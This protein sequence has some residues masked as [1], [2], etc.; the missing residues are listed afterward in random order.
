M[1]G[2]TNAPWHIKLGNYW[3]KLVI[4]PQ[5]MQLSWRREPVP[6][7]P[8]RFTSQAATQASFPPDVR[9]PYTFGEHSGGMGL[10]RID[11]AEQAVA[12]NYAGPRSGNVD[13]GLDA[14]LGNRV[15][16]SAYVNRTTLGTTITTGNQD[17][18]F[19][20]SSYNQTSYLLAGR[21]VFRRTATTSWSLLQDLGVGISGTDIIEFRGTQ[22]TPYLYVACGTANDIQV[23]DIAGASWHTVNNTKAERWAKI[24]DKL[25]R[26]LSGEVDAAT[27]GGT[28]PTFAGPII[29]G[30]KVGTC[31]GL[32]NHSNRITIGKSSGLFLLTAD[33]G[34]L[35]QNLFPEFWT[36]P[37]TDTYTFSKGVSF[38]NQLLTIYKK[39]LAAFTQDFAYINVGLDK[40]I[41]NN[42]PVTGQVTAIASDGNHIYYALDSG[43]IIKGVVTM[44]SGVITGVTHHPWLY[45]GTTR[46]DALHVDLTD[47]HLLALQGQQVLAMRLSPTGNPLDDSSYRYCPGGVLYEAPFYAGFSQELKQV[48]TIQADAQGLSGSSYVQH[49][50]RTTSSGNYIELT[51]SRQT[52]DP[53]A[54]YDLATPPKCRFYQAAFTMLSG[55]PGSSTTTPVLRSHTISYVVLTDPLMSMSFIVD[56]TEGAMLDDGSR[57]VLDPDT[58]AYRL[59]QLVNSGVTQLR[60]PWGRLYDVTIPLEGYVEQGGEPHIER[61]HDLYVRMKVVTQK[62]RSRGTFGLLSQYTFS[63]IAPYKFSALPLTI[64]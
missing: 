16:L 51:S 63:Q 35:D 17:A 32:Y 56:L 36:N 25:Y 33:T 5:T 52:V 62:Q 48:F 58:A 29:V 23:Y 12:Y 13:E 4:E 55:V 18:K 40:L 53:G 6:F 1:V 19:I 31:N 41:E 9:V 2:K 11:G 45:V 28:N 10:S 21:Y 24:D 44:S 60:D 15:I 3:W 39:G 61:H 49:S 57:Q 7:F 50:Y 26:Y 59:E 20:T 54:R 43:Y 27:N 42:T 30:D 34:T 8:T 38:K 37:S 47:S 22:A 64:L 46:V 14:S